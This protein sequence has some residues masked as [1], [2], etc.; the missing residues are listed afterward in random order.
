MSAKCH[1]QT[2]GPRP[3]HVA[4][5]TQTHTPL[6]SL[7]LLGPPRR[8]SKTEYKEPTNLP[9]EGFG[10]PNPVRV[11]LLVPFSSVLLRLTTPGCNGMTGGGGRI[12]AVRRPER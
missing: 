11:V 10:F 8:P 1:K 7:A 6:A 3:S 9:K 4:G 12:D 2:R 5:D